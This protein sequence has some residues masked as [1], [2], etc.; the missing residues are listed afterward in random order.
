[1]KNL[2]F[3]VLA[4]LCAAATA[5]AQC[6]AENNAFKAG[7]RVSYNLY[8]NWKFIW[9]KV[10]NATFSTTSTTYRSQ[11]AYQMSLLA[12]TNKTADKFFKMRDT[13]TSVVSTRLEPLYYRKA[14]EE[15]SRFTIDEVWYSYAGGQSTINQHRL[16]EGKQT[17]QLTYTDTRCIFDMVSIMSWARSLN[18]ASLS[19]GDVQAFPLATGKRIEEGRLVYLGR[20]N[21]DGDDDHKYRCQV[22]SYVTDRDGKQEEIIKFYVSDD[23]NRLPICLDINLNFG[24]AK[25]FFKGVSGNRYPLTSRI[26]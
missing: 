8:F 19:E 25:V 23:S 15:G 12:V 14:A 7:E 10:G 4:A 18:F 26:K 13:L 3:F 5:Q 22:F 21:V 16:L 11:P 24:T 1:M 9:K 2:L 6:A 17:A 20:K